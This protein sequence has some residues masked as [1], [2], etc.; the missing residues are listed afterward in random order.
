MGPRDWASRRSSHKTASDFF[1]PAQ[2]AWSVP[3]TP[4]RAPPP[5][6]LR[7]GEGERGR[8]RGDQPGCLPFRKSTYPR[9]TVGVAPCHGPVMPLLLNST[10]EVG[11]DRAGA[12]D[13]PTPAP[14]CA[15]VGAGAASSTTDCWLA[16]WLSSAEPETGCAPVAGRS[17]AVSSSSARRVVGCPCRRPAQGC[18]Q[19]AAGRSVIGTWLAESSL[20][21]LPLVFT[22]YASAAPAR[23]PPGGAGWCWALLRGAPWSMSS[24][25]RAPR[26]VGTPSMPRCGA[27]APRLH[28]L[29]LQ[30]RQGRQRGLAR[31]IRWSAGVGGISEFAI[32]MCFSRPKLL[33][34]AASS[35]NSDQQK[36]RL[37]ANGPKLTFD[38]AGAVSSCACCLEPP[39]YV[40]A[41]I[42]RAIQP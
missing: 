13:Q 38:T 14:L 24:A 17:W 36:P 40:Y 18:P 16:S 34:L 5:G 6:W 12:A 22:K 35:S 3:E 29:G 28:G 15:V 31:E 27:A 33:L 26:Q 23:C 4:G 42:Q 20:P 39:A 37:L 10:G 7:R 41:R 8:D 9:V 2:R 21:S 1:Q 19:H 25:E 30:C 32:P 11:I